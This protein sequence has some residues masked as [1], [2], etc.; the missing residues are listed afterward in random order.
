M[1]VEVMRINRAIIKYN[2]DNNHEIILT[3]IESM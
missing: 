1:R 3:I 2:Y